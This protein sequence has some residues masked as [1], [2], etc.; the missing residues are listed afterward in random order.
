[1]VIL[2]PFYPFL[3]KPEMRTAAAKEPDKS[4]IMTIMDDPN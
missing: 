3:L 1:M 2:L 4:T